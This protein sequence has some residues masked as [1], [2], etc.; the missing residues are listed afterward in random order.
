MPRYGFNFLWMFIYNGQKPAAVDEKALDFLAESGLNFVRIP[1]DYRFW[2]ENFD[3][4][5]PREEV[6][7]AIDSYI[8]ACRSRKLH[9][10]LNM[11]RVPGYCINRPEL[12]W[13][14]LWLDKVAQDGLAFQW[15]T[16][17]KRYQG[18]PGK[19]LSFDLIN[20]PPSVGSRGMNR[21]NHASV[22]RR[23]T[24]AIH[25]IDPQRPVVIDGIDGG[26]GA[27]PELADL[28]VTHSGRGYAPAAISHYQAEWSRGWESPDGLPH[29]PGVL[30]NGR[31]WDKDTLREVYAPWREVEAQG[32]PIHIGEMGCYNKIPNAVALAWFADLLSLFRE[33]GGG[34]AFWN[35]EGAFG[36]VNHGRPGAR[37]EQ[38]G[39]YEVDI[40]LWNLFLE[41][42]VN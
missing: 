26:W 6:F 10:S 13:D 25:A 7:E 33:F 30:W 29:W 35:F 8:A 2:T 21:E 28:P 22:I 16:F 5:H 34:Y 32:V 14:N 42:R 41:N 19:E 15:E 11:H 40:D 4:F 39:G 31:R 17:A 9:A 27:I 36:V 37:Y 1:T 18:I 23:V 24:A 20:E 12:E 38:R 3:Y